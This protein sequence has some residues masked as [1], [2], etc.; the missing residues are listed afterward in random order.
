[1]ILTVSLGR[2]YG[3]YAQSL[4]FVSFLFP[5]VIGT[6][7]FFNRVL[8]R[9]FL[10]R[11]EYF[12]FFQYL[13]YT[14]VISV[15]LELL[16]LTLSMVLFANFDYSNLNPKTT[17][18]YFL[19]IILYFIV[20]AN[21]IMVIIQEYFKGEAKNRELEAQR[22]NREERFLVVRSE[23]KNVNICIEDIEYIEGLGNYIQIHLS[24]G[25]KILTKEGISN[26][27]ERLNDRFLRI[28]RSILVYRNKISSFNRE[29]ITLGEVE[30]PLSRK[31]K[32]E[33][34]KIL[35]KNS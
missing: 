31:Y 18:I 26:I 35:N 7:Y 20:F 8:V 29:T 17:D 22:N 3:G 4:Y 11:K 24:G 14:L 6:S 9:R 30:L 23:R 13:I 33:V 28:H 2:S 15:Y 16:I 5:V 10:F 19:T 21:S 25:E 12:R 32:E 1:L 27:H 34:Y